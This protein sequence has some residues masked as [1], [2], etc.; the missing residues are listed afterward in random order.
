VTI[1]LRTNVIVQVCSVMAVL[2][3]TMFGNPGKSLTK[4]AFVTIAIIQAA[5]A[6]AAHR[7]TFI[8]APLVDRHLKK[9]T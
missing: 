9:M 8:G 6:Y 1:R 2:L 7:S 4:T 5:V 3:I